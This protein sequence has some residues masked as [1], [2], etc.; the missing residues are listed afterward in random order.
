MLL[1]SPAAARRTGELAGGLRRAALAGLLAPAVATLW[2]LFA[3]LWR[4]PLDA[5]L[6][7]GI[8]WLA[9]VA[10]SHASVL[11]Q[12]GGAPLA[13]APRV[14][15][16]L[17]SHMPFQAALLA[18]AGLVGAA[19]AAAARSATGLLALALALVI[20]CVAL[21]RIGTTTLALPARQDAD[22]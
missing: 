20:T 4:S 9:V 16:G 22:A 11:A 1:S 17:G 10:A 13:R 5:A 15:E 21:S 2:A 19:H 8:G 14:F 12:V 6:H 18:A 7:C 3:F